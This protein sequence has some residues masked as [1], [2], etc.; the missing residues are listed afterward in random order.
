MDELIAHV[1]E[2]AVLYGVGAAFTL[3]LIYVTRKYSVP[4][5]LYTVEYTIYA[6]IMHLVV[7]IIVGATRWFKESSS[8]KALREDGKPI[9]TPE[10]GTPLINFWDTDAYDPEVIWKVEVGFLV[11]VMLL[12]WRYRPMK[13]QRRAKRQMQEYASSGSKRG[14]AGS[15][16][17]GG[18]GKGRGGG[19]IPRGTR[20]R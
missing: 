10:W 1:Q 4:A 20:G 2:N 15:Y 19:K 11:V 17:A 3:P 12:M 18:R 16:K 5:I 7:W 14:K 8:M 9:D 13:I 6:C